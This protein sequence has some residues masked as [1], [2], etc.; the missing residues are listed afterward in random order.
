MPSQVALP[1]AAFV[2]SP[3][4][5]VRGHIKL[6]FALG[7][8]ILAHHPSTRILLL[9]QRMCMM[10]NIGCL[11]CSALLHLFKKN[12][13]CFGLGGDERVTV[14]VTAP[15][16]LYKPTNSPTNQLI[17]QPIDRP[18]HQPAN[19]AASQAAE[20]LINSP[21]HQPAR[22]TRNHM[23]NQTAHH[24]ISPPPTGRQTNSPTHQLTS[25]YI[26]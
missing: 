17:N 3:Q 14:V 22:N 18:T 25:R 7:Q 10:R 26:N 24:P 16:S 9:V 1:T 23:T 12:E 21:S 20:Q 8:I 5:T 15:T 4:C 19:K 11:G 13:S 2:G 6:A